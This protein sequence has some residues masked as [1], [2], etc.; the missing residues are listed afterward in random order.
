MLKDYPAKRHAKLGER[1]RK[2]CPNSLRGFAWCLLTDANTSGHVIKDSRKGSIS[3]TA[4]DQNM[5]GETAKLMENLMKENGNE[6]TLYDIHKDVSRTLPNHIYFQEK[7]SSGQN[8][9]FAVLKCLSIVEP[10]VGYV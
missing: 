5:K 1:G 10:E 2:G 7:F 4:L 6:Q 3:G 9:L 8:D